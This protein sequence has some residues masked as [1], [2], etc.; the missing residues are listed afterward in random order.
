[1]PESGSLAAALWVRMRIAE[2]EGAYDFN[3]AEVRRLG[4]AFS[5][6]TR[7]TSLIVLDR[8][9]DYVR[10]EIVPPTEMRADYQR[11]LASTAQQRTGERKSHLDNVVRMFAQKAAWWNR[12]F[13]K[14]REVKKEAAISVGAVAGNTSERALQERR[15]TRADVRDLARTNGPAAQSAPQT[16]AMMAAKSMMAPTVYAPPAPG[17]AVPAETKVTS[18]TANAGTTSASI[19]LQK[20]QPDSPYTARL[21]TGAPVHVPAPGYR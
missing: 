20:W 6:V 12:D 13:P 10:Y 17:A 21:A 19:Q 2:L 1:M 5:L 3:R 11:M 7:E 16:P 8:I 14:H 18:P 15:E 4:R 9:E